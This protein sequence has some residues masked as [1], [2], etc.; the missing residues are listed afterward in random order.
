MQTA[1]KPARKTLA[2]AGNILYA[3]HDPNV[4]AQQSELF[5]RAGYSVERAQGRKA[6]EQALR[7]HHYDAVV[8]GHTLNKDD[9]HHLPYMAKK[10]NVEVAVLV[11]HASGKHPAVD[12]AMDSREGDKAVLA[13]LNSLVEEKAL[14]AVS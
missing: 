4:L 8:L 10:A 14:A 2:T 3:E 11:L 5:E 12:F 13:M 9:R 1:A 7:N 6:A